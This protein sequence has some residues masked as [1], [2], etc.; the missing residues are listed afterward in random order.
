MFTMRERARSA[1]P[2]RVD[3]IVDR[4]RLDDRYA[5][6]TGRILRL[7]AP[8]G[9]G[10]STIL[11]R[12]ACDDWRPVCWLDLEPIDNDPLVLTSAIARGLGE[13]SDIDYAPGPEGALATDRLHG[14]V[15]PSFAEVLRSCTT[16]I[17]VVLDDLHRVDSVE[18]AEAIETLAAHMPADSTLVLSGRRQMPDGWL[19]RLRLEPGVIDLGID[20]LAFDLAETEEMLGLMG[21]EFDAASVEELTAEFGGWPAGLRLAG[22]ALEEERR[23]GE[24]DAAGLGRSRFVTDYLELEWLGRLDPDDERLLMEVACLGRFT[25]EMCQDVLG[26]SGCAARL[27]DLRRRLPFLLPL[28]QRDE[29]YRLHSL[30][31]SLLSERLRDRNRPRFRAIHAAASRWWERR[32]DIDLAIE[33]AVRGD[34]L[35]RCEHLI[36][37][38]FGIYLAAGHYPIVKRWVDHLPEAR[39]AATRRL[40][41]V[42][43]IM[44]TQA[45]DGVTALRWTRRLAGGLEGLDQDD[46]TALRADALLALLDT[47]PPDQLIPLGEGARNGSHGTWRAFACWGLGGDRVRLG[48]LAAARDDFEAGA[49]EAE[50]VGAH[51]LEANL[52]ASVA[53]VADLQGDTAAVVE[54]TTTAEHLLRV[55]RTAHVPTTGIVAAMSSLVAARREHRDAAQESLERARRHL[56]GFVGVAPH[57]N[58]LA[59]I[60]MAKV[61]LL[62][63][64]AAGARTHLSLVDRHVAMGSPAGALEAALEPLRATVGAAS[65]LLLDRTWALTDAEMRVLK[66]LPTNLSLG[67]IAGRLYI[68]RNTVKSHVAAIYRKMGTASRGDAVERARASGLLAPDSSAPLDH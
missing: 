25:A 68:S 29:W 6:A 30:L 34:D 56:A 41:A 14:V 53:A 60:A 24:R 19:A 21:V 4:A 8:G 52:R 10:K 31:A 61:C 54:F 63:D 66:F 12:W 65:D 59:N 2:A 67:D 18:A 51:V 37:E 50:L 1:G 39:I 3:R 47:A 46:E 40:Q 43:A 33:H 27:R 28:D 42:A 11:T 16:P 45:G 35:A 5:T 9:Y 49:F 20:D 23:N 58:I 44:C 48:D 7:I 38:H 57:V 17:V 62:G 55:H 64:D 22:I 26:R 15:I 32:G 13:L 36:V